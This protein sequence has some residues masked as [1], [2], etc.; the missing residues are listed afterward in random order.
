MLR[1]I[2]KSVVASNLADKC[3]IQIAYGIGMQKPISIS[4]ETFGTA[5]IPEEEI[6]KKIETHFDLTPKGIIDYLSLKEPIY[7]LT[8]NYGHFG[9]DNLPWERVVKLDR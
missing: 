9:K 6:I 4:I 2:A 1:H 8:T 3:E 7:T 5:K